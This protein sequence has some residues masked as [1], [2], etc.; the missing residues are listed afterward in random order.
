MK[1][2]YESQYDCMAQI[3]KVLLGVENSGVMSLRDHSPLLEKKKKSFCLDFFDQSET[4]IL[5]G[6]S[7]LYRNCKTKNETLP[8]YPVRI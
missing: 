4:S 7:N 5:Q 3:T 2:S 8:G 1:V 6:F